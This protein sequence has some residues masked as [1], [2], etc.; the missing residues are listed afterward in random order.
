MKIC[1][2]D[3]FVAVHHTFTVVK[4][5]TVESNT[6]NVTQTPLTEIV[7]VCV[8][9]C[10]GRWSRLPVWW[11]CRD[12]PYH[13][14]CWTGSWSV[15][16]GPSGVPG[17]RTWQCV[18][19]WRRAWDNW[20]RGLAG[21]TVYNTSIKKSLESILEVCSVCRVFISMASFHS[22]FWCVSPYMHVEGEELGNEA[23][24]I[25]EVT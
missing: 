17:S 22:H 13:D 24:R 25:L 16:S 2:L 12:T 18:G 10:C 5:V 14:S 21:E 11:L 20:Q 6:L 23:S 19:T 7:C 1:A 9:V 8:C 3:K 15:R 4:I